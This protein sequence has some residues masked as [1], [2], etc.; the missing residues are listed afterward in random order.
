VQE[1]LLA[2]W[3]RHNN[4]LLVLFDNVPTD[5]FSA[6]PACSRG[7]TVAHQF[8]HIER[9]R[10]SWLEY[11]A[12][13]KRPKLPRTTKE[14]LADIDEL[15]GCLIETG[16][17]IGD[18]LSLALRSEAKIRMFG[19]QPVRWLMYLVSHE[20][21]HRGQIALALKQNG[22]R[23]PDSIAVQGLW[24]GGCLV[25]ELTSRWP[26]PNGINQRCITD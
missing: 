8:A 6:V 1:Q 26:V 17:T 25:A 21:H 14:E 15:R 12:T 13:G 4:I 7:R 10:S 18:Y 22:L 16:Q 24:A 5:G 11:H 23:L 19:Q 9:V 3:Q 2:A 20:S